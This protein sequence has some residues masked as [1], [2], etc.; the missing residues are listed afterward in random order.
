MR[1]RTVFGVSLSRAATSATVRYSSANT[2]LPLSHPLS[3][4]GVMPLAGRERVQRNG[5]GDLVA[6]ISKVV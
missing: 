1:L 6:P 4:T 2:S 5:A 3:V